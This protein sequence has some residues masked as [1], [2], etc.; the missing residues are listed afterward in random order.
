MCPGNAKLARL[1]TEALGDEVILGW[2]WYAHHLHD[3]LKT[4]HPLGHLWRGLLGASAMA[5]SF[6]A[7]GLLPL[8]EVTD[9]FCGRPRDD[10][11]PDLG[12]IEYSAGPCVIAES[13]V[14]VTCS[15][16]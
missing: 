3:G 10:G 2:L 5:C 4:T 16:Y 9:D 12:A 14:R 13:W 1:A 15:R 7:L 8:P 11:V 6:T